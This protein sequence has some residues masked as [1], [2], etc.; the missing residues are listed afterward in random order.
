MSTKVIF[1]RHG[2]VEPSALKH[3]FD[4]EVELSQMGIDQAKRAGDDLNTLT[5]GVMEIITSPNKRAVQTA[6][7]IKDTIKFCKV[8]NFTID[9]TIRNVAQLNHDPYEVHLRAKI[10]ILDLMIRKRNLETIV[11]VSHEPF[12]RACLS[13]LLNVP[14]NSPVISVKHCVPILEEI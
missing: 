12:I 11:V 5:R 6:E 3:E 13:I 10:F 8:K 2:H 1:I 9:P 14:L 7:I 4:M